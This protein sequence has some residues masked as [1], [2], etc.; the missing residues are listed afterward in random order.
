MQIKIEKKS[1]TRGEVSLITIRNSLN[2]EVA[3]TDFGGAVYYIAYPDKS[4]EMGRV[5]DAPKDFEYFLNSGSNY[6]KAV[7]PV[8]IRI[9]DAVATIDNNTYHFDQNEGVNCLHSGNANFGF[10]FYD[11]EIKTNKRKV[12][13][14]FS[15]NVKDGEGGFPGNVKAKVIYTI[16]DNKKELNI[17]FTGKGDKT[18]L[19]NM[20][21]HTYF[22]LNGGRDSI[23]NQELYLR[24]SKVC[25]FD[26]DLIIKR[27][28][29]VPSLLDFREAKKLGPVVT[30][31]SLL[32][33]H[34]HGIDHVFLLDSCDKN[35]PSAILYDPESKRKLTV[36]TSVNAIVC[37]TYNYPSHLENLA[38][39]SDEQN[40]ALT[41][42]TVTPNL[43]L[44]DITYT[45]DQTYVATVKYKFN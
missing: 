36:Y 27:F 31:P 23:H 16:Y 10:K 2:F 42:E 3:L 35:I 1:T 14:V 43:N 17:K 6:G 25:D 38:G 21:S 12:D 24:A 41:F 44:Q 5:T 13:V 8:A 45:K 32:A 26:D 39:V 19:L 29:D 15:I 37:Y 18:T 34:A 4:G 9:K 7:G 30:N 22:N 28:I 11:Y 33:H 40:F 20:T